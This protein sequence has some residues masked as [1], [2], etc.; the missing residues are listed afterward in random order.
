MTAPNRLTPSGMVGAPMF[1]M[2]RKVGFPPPRVF[3]RVAGG[4]SRPGPPPVAG[5]DGLLPETE[6]RLRRRRVRGGANGASDRTH[7]DRT[8]A[9]RWPRVV[10]TAASRTRRG[11]RRSSVPPVAA[12][13][14]GSWC[15][16]RPGWWHGSCRFRS[17]RT[18][19]SRPNSQVHCSFD[20]KVWTSGCLWIC[21]VPNPHVNGRV[22][23]GRNERKPLLPALPQLYFGF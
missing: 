17:S 7:E 4:G 6:R 1:S 5:R 11:R 2:N 8:V 14:G 18:T 20:L 23:V 12:P 9:Q 19:S 16:W 15:R 10:A 3:R 13:R 22:A 21:P